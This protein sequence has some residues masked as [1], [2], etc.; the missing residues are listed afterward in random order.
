MASNEWNKRIF[1]YVDIKSINILWLQLSIHYTVFRI[2]WNYHHFL[3]KTVRSSKIL[4][5]YYY[6]LLLN[7]WFHVSVTRVCSRPILIVNCNK[8]NYSWV[9]SVEYD[10]RHY[11]LAW[12]CS[13]TGLTI[14]SS[15]RVYCAINYGFYFC[16]FGIDFSAWK[17][18]L[19]L[20]NFQNEKRNLNRALDSFV[21]HNYVV[22]S[23]V[24]SF[25][26]M[27]KF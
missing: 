15:H 23:F 2:C 11:V 17:I 10:L 27:R 9:S 16:V 26:C 24:C 5:D 25:V 20:I 3:C 8:W 4:F 1:F 21:W 12:A 7:R 6:Y 22:N 13:N 18:K 19:I 14:L